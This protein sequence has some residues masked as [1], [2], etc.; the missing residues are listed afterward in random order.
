[1][2]LGCSNL[3][4]K[5]NL[6]PSFLRRLQWHQWDKTTWE[7][8]VDIILFS[9]FSFESFLSR[10]QHRSQG[11]SQGHQPEAE[12]GDSAEGQRLERSEPNPTKSQHNFCGMCEGQISLYS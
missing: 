11:W 1:M 6:S 4:R 3:G 9:Q 12:G 2:A 7:I 8:L 10:D 5:G